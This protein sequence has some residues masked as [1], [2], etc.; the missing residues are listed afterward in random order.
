VKPIPPILVVVQG[1]KAGIRSVFYKLNLL[2]RR[3]EAVFAVSLRSGRGGRPNDLSD[4]P[5]GAF[6]MLR[7]QLKES[8]KRFLL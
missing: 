3:N 5:W 4:D 6:R 7:Q 2:W 1:K 8:V